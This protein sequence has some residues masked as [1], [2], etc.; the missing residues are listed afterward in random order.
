MVRRE[1]GKEARRRSRLAPGAIGF[2]VAMTIAVVATREVAANDV[3]PIFPV[4]GAPD[5]PVSGDGAS[6]HYTPDC[7]VSFGLNFGPG[8]F[9]IEAPSSYEPGMTYVITIDLA[10]T[11]QA[12]WGFQMTAIDGLL[13][14][15]GTFAPS[16]ANTQRQIQFDSFTDRK[17]ISHT[18][19]G[20]AVGQANGNSWSFQWI[21]PDTD[22]GP[23]T[24]YAAGNAANNNNLSL[25][26]YIYTTSATIPVPEPGALAAG[27]L[28]LTTAAAL[29]RIKD[30]PRSKDPRSKDRPRGAA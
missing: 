7:H 6:C 19:V 24:F 5:E 12:R 8:T 28:A 25:G 16:D 4:T 29:A 10:Q 27:F 22:V 23:V 17:Y 2:A 26:D 21:A 30:R 11:G 13:Q 1:G 15:A 18:E 3:G 20:T 14:G 9:A